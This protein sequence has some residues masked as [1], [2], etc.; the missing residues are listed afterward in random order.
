MMLLRIEYVA[1]ENM[2]SAWDKKDTAPPAT[3]R[4]LGLGMDALRFSSVVVPRR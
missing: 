1:S 3:D 4:L 2:H